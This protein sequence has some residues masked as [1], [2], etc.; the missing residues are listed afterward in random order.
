MALVGLAA[1]ASPRG[2]IT[3]KLVD[4]GLQPTAARC[5]ANEMVENLN[6]RQLR[7][8]GAAAQPGQYGR[9]TL[10]ELAGRLNRVNDPEIARVLTRAGIN[11]IVLG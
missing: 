7:A 6:T 3:T 2:Q 5:V 10:G 9:L 1:C 4:A 11:C 8:I